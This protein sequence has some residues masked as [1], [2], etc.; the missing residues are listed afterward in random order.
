MRV[1]TEQGGGGV[2]PSHDIFL[3]L[4]YMTELKLK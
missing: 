1:A 2:C 3:V 4:K